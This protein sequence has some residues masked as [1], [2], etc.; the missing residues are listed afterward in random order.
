MPPDKSLERQNRS[1]ARSLLAVAAGTLL[2]LLV[3]LT[4][5]QLTTEV[6]WGVEDFLAAGGL[7]FSTGVGMVVIARYARRTAYRVAFSGM[8]LL[9]LVIVWAELAVG[10]FT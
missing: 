5:M 1:L 9:A 2:V 3:P 4:A 10:I 8:L 6:R 7:I